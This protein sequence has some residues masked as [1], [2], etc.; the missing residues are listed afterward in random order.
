M[1]LVCPFIL[2]RSETFHTAQQV[3]GAGIRP[4]LIGPFS[5]NRKSGRLG[6]RP[7]GEATGYRF[8]EV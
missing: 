3:F 1:Y 7:G 8:P 5:G 6:R 2:N 4:C